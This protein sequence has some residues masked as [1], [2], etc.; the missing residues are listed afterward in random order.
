MY[1]ALESLSFSVFELLYA[2]RSYSWLYGGGWAQ[3]TMGLHQSFLRKKRTWSHARPQIT[4]KRIIFNNGPPIWYHL[5]QQ[6]A[7]FLQSEGFLLPFV[8][9]YRQLEDF[10]APFR[11][12]CHLDQKASIGQSGDF[13]HS[14][15][16]RSDNGHFLCTI[17][18]F[19]VKKGIFASCL[20][21]PSLERTFFY[22]ILRFHFNECPIDPIHLK[23]RSA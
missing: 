3:N 15:R 8:W 20:K 19:I 17:S 14:R 9:M 16:L 21:V 22:I 23:T 10:L 12:V 2:L 7:H 18:V 6:K 11:R 4:M 5:I 13:H 1:F